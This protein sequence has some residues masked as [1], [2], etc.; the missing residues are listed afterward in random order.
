MC[1]SSK[2]PVTKRLST[3]GRPLSPESDAILER[4][5]K[6]G[7]RLTRYYLFKA[8]H[9]LKVLRRGSALKSWGAKLAKRIGS[10]PS[11]STAFGQTAPSSPP[12]Q[13]G[14]YRTVTKGAGTLAGRIQE[15]IFLLAL[16]NKPPSPC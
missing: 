13:G 5:S 11:P 12:A 14:R 9:Q 6:R 3:P 7:D 15:G 8:S 4:I 10:W 16:V 1:F 2:A